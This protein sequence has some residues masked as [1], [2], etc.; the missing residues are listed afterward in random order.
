MGSGEVGGNGS[1]QWAIVQDKGKKKPKHDDIDLVAYANMGGPSKGSPPEHFKITICY[2]TVAEAL[3]AQQTVQVQ[4]A[5]LVLFLKAEDRKGQ[6]RI[7]W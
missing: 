5:C 6:I 2:N 1:V 4:G 3:A 7:D